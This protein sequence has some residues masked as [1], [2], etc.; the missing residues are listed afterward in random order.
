MGRDLHWYVIHKKIDHEIDKPLCFNWEFQPDEDE[1]ND[2]IYN[3]VNPCPEEDKKI[4]FKEYYK[5]KC[6]LILDYKYD[7]NT[8]KFCNKCRM[9]ACG[10]FYDS[11]FVVANKHIGHSYSNPIWSSR[12]NVKDLY[13]GNNNT[14]F[15]RRFSDDKLYREIFKYDI[16]QA[17]DS[18]EELG[19]PLR[20]SDKEAK[21][22]TM[23]IL[24]FLKKWTETDEYFVIIEDEC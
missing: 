16:D 12:W 21:E 14:D 3:K 4:N 19:D 9:Y 15:V 18:I 23:H 1:I 8:E 10:G 7:K 5:K 13:M 17:Y 11:P 2:E 24:D 6:N 22:E 20:T